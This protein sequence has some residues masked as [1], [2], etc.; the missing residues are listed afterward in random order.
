VPLLKGNKRPPRSEEWCKKIS[1]AK[2]GKP[3]WNKGIPLGRASPMKDKRHTEESNK[4]NREAHLGKPGTRNGMHHT[5]ETK[6]ILS[7][8]AKT[9]TGERNGFYGKTH[10][11]E[12]R[13]KLSTY[14][15][16][17]A[18]GYIDGTAYF[19]Y[20]PKFNKPRKRAT[21]NF[22]DN[23]CIACG[24]HVTEN[25]VHWK[26]GFKQ[27]EHHV[28]HIDHDKEQGCSG[29]PFNLIPLCDS[30][31]G[32][33]NHNREEYRHYINKTLEQGFLWGIWSRQEYI[34]QVMYAE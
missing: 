33:E 7:E 1:D 15:G 4:K 34:D 8:Q 31:H 24:K 30:C 10:T 26:I 17:K 12:T 19:P 16:I 22:F 27:R 13:K 3:A 6:K 25:I 14:C 29:K 18:S 9:R 21:R 32:K 20:C 5:I 11:E 28:H 2:K 23:F